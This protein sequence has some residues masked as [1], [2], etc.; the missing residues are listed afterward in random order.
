LSCFMRPG[1]DKQKKEKATRNRPLANTPS[2]ASEKKLFPSSESTSWLL[3]K[4]S[5]IATAPS[6]RVTTA[7]IYKAKRWANFSFIYTTQAGSSL[8]C[9]GRSLFLGPGH[10]RLVAFSLHRLGCFF[11]CFF[12][13]YRFFLDSFILKDFRGRCFSFR[14]FCFC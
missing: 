10:R 13:Y 11:C 9:L 8:R 3:S 12:L 4:P 14:R 2:L 6:E 5:S 7:P 1:R